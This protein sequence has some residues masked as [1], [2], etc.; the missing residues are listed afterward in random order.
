MMAADA[1]QEMAKS[2]EVATKAAQKAA[3]A[4]ERTARW[5]FWMAVILLTT[6]IIMLLK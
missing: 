4:A 3:E 2:S 5:T 6:A 1:A